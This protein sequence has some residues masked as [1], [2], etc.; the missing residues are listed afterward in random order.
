[1]PIVM[2]VPCAAVSGYVFNVGKRNV[3]CLW[4][5]VGVKQTVEHRQN[6]GGGCGVARGTVV[7]D[8]VQWNHLNE[9]SV[10]GCV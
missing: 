2:S 7:V 5:C 3:C 8:C 4:D 1:M 10:I 6:V 9:A